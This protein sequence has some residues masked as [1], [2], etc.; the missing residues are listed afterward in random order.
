MISSSASPHTSAFMTMPGLPPNGTSSTVWCTS[1]A[2]RRRSCTRNSRSPRAA[3]FPIS[4]TRSGLSKY[5]GK[6]V[7]MSTRSPTAS[8]LYSAERRWFEVEQAGGRVDDDQPG[9]HIHLGHDR[10]HERDQAFLA[11]AVRALDHEQVLAVVEHVA[12]HAHLLAVR[13]AH[14]EPDQLMVAELVR[15]ARARELGGVDA[16]PGP[17]QLCGRGPVRDPLEA[18]QELAGVPARPG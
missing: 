4:E 12:D 17:G 18:D 3:A 15:V 16:Q 10:L 2:Q 7:T 13:R 1:V 6:I 11:S 9:V 8:P 14:A 5:S